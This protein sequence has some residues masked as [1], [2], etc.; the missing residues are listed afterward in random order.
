[1]S[2]RPGFGRTPL[3]GTLLPIADG[4]TH[5]LAEVARAARA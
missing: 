1:M 3:S 4:W 2:R 5:D